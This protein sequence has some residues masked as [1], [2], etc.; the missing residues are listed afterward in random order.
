LLNDGKKGKG[1]Q[2]DVLKAYLILKG[3]K[4]GG[5]I[6]E[7]IDRIYEYW[8]NR[9]KSKANDMK[10]CLKIYGDAKRRG[11]PAPVIHYKCTFNG[12]DRFTQLIGYLK[13]VAKIE[14][15]NFLV[16]CW[17]VKACVVQ[18]YSLWSEYQFE[19]D[20]MLENTRLFDFLQEVYENLLE[21]DLEI[22]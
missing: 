17:V 9:S 12:I 2:S 7:K 8:H 14:N 5:T 10:E 13:V 21:K 22:L 1:K 20:V 15:V 11:K 19:I 18:A 6:E 3:K 4:S 16:F